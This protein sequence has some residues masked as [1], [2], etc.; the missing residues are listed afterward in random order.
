MVGNTKVGSDTICALATPPG[1]G[2][3][4]VV[5]VSGPKAFEM[6]DLFFQGGVRIPHAEGHTIH[7]GWWIIENQRVD[8]A[9]ASIFRAPHSYTG[10]DVVEIGCH[11]GVFVVEQIT[12][13][14]LSSG[15]RLA[16]PGEFT[17]RAFINGKL[18]LTQAEAV[19]DLI[20]AESRVGAQTAA[21]QLS[22]GFTAR[23]ANLRQG[24]LD[25]IG[26]LELELDFSE[27][28]VEFVDRTTLLRTL[29][30]IISDIDATAATA[31]SAE[32]LRAGF[33]VAV[34]GY[35]NV[36]K[37]SLFNALLQRD[38]AI[39]S[40]VPGTTRDYLSE[41]IF[42]DGYSIHLVDTAGLRSTEDQVELQGI[43]LTTSLIEQS[44]LIMVVNDASLGRDH[45]V[46]LLM[47]LKGRFTDIPTVTIQNKIDLIPG[48]DANL[49]TDDIVCSAQTGKG[50]D[51]L[52]GYLL[53][54]VRVSTSGVS[55]VLINARQAHLL[56]S[57]A[58]SLRSARSGVEG[59]LT[60]DLLA[61][62][63]R[64]AIRLLGDIAGES[65]NP[66]VLESVFSRFCIGK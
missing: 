41:V 57:A 56:R 21:R 36:G 49:D 13:S 55:D 26:L 25:V 40:D 33:H 46:S 7:Y 24:L 39:V 15:V 12:T 20:H 61:V 19:A 65:W 11:G 52:R 54:A 64:S 63:I 8:S 18:D 1:V 2:G 6:C 43:A 62:D 32:V 31:H 60:G 66:D 16:Q 17:R 27:E 34:V 44:D 5:R 35:P 10:E 3:L 38:R 45:S 53:E 23:L 37:S 28:D 9:T 50:L 22:G 4:A 14:L 47:D 59:G 58:E 51:G 29:S 30:E 42:L 48:Y